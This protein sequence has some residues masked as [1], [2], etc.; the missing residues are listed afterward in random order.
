MRSEKE[1]TWVC[2][3]GRSCFQQNGSIRK[4]G[5][6]FS[7]KKMCKVSALPLSCRFDCKNISYEPNV[8]C[9]E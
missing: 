4:P 3:G 7:L 5:F 2:N 6:L 1:R 8:M 9:T